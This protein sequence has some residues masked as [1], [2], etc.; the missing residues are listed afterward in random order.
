MRRMKCWYCWRKERSLN[1]KGCILDFIDTTMHRPL[2]GYYKDRPLGNNRAYKR[3]VLL[4]CLWKDFQKDL[5]QVG[6]LHHRTARHLLVSEIEAENAP[7]GY[8]VSRFRRPMSWAVCY[9]IEGSW[10]D[11]LMQLPAVR[12]S[13]QLSQRSNDLRIRS[14]Q[15]GK[16]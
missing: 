2:P 10:T 8:L 12:A 9:S 7:F 1:E 3:Y 15:R 16:R 5:G 14:I 6:Q 4:P 11:W 13:K